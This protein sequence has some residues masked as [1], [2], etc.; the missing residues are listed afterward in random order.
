MPCDHPH[1]H[2]V[3]TDVNSHC[4]AMRSGRRLRHQCPDCGELIGEF[5]AH[6]RAAPDTPEVVKDKLRAWRESEDARWQKLSDEY[7]Q[8]QL[9]YQRRQL[10]QDAAWWAQYSAYLQSD[11]WQQLRPRVFDRAGGICEGCG[12]ATAT[13]VHHLTYKHVTNEFLW[14][15][16]AICDN[17][18]ERVHDSD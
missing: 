3:W 2:L 11:A 15:L 5:V 13:Q 1:S 17:C 18:H 14:E 16:V 4:N 8:R 12:Q 7:Q 6:A 10:D 9:E